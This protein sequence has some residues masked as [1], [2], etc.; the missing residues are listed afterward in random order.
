MIDF[1]NTYIEHSVGYLLNPSKRIYIVYLL[2]SLVLAFYVYKTSHFK[3]SF[4]KYIFKKKVWLSR[5]AFIDYK[6]FLLNGLIKVV[7]IV[8]YLY[9][10]TLLAFY[11]NEYLVNHYDYVHHPLGIE[12]A[13]VLYTVVLTLTVDF[14]VFV[15]HYLMHKVPFLWEFH[16]VHHSATSMNPIT[17]Y[18]IHPIELLINNVVSTFVFSCVTGVFNYWSGGMVSIWA[19]WG[20]NVFSVLFFLLG[21]NLRHSH[22]RLAYFNVLEYIFMSPLQHQIHHSRR[23]EHWNKNMGSRLAIWDYLFGTLYLSQNAS[24]LSFGLGAGQDSEYD[25]FK[26]NL[27]YPFW[28]AFKILFKRTL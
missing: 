18:R 5:S 23:R 19:F 28:K 14:F 20:A 8:P 16:K 9:F 3:T 2:V 21:A 27:W 10:G 7:L 12:N 25:S 24:K 22:V 11:I 4:L 26:S 13:I 6:L 17:Q 1:L 15:V